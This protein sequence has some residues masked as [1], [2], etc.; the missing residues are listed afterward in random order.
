M[1][2]KIFQK[3]LPVSLIYADERPG[4]KRVVNKIDLKADVTKKRGGFV[5]FIRQLAQIAKKHEIEPDIKPRE[6]D[7]KNEVKR[8]ENK[9]KRP[10]RSTYSGDPFHNEAFVVHCLATNRILQPIK[11]SRNEKEHHVARAGKVSTDAAVQAAEQEIVAK[12]YHKDRHHPY[13]IQCTDFSFQ[14]QLFRTLQK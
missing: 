4:A 14:N 9:Q 11:K 12:Q 13:V 3:S 6:P 8:D 2:S 1:V 10:D 7:S 5:G